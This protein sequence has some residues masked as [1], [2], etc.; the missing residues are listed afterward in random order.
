VSDVTKAWP[1]TARETNALGVSPVPNADIGWAVLSMRMG[2][3]VRRRGWNGRGM[4]IFLVPGSTF[5]VNRPPLLGI[6]SPGTVVNYQPHV[7]MI[8]AQ[9]TVVP[10]LCSQSDLLATDWEIVP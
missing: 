6:Y 2:H 4:C 9:G 8:T 1:F 10:W 5:G 7:D 3:R